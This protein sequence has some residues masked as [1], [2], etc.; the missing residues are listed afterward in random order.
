M[1]AQP[2]GRGAGGATAARRRDRA[3]S[4]LRRRGHFGGAEGG[5][6][7]GTR[8]E[9]TGDRSSGLGQGAAR[10][11]PRGAA[12]APLARAHLPR[13]RPDRHAVRRDPPG[14]YTGVEDRRA[15][16][17][18]RHGSV[19]SRRHRSGAVRTPGRT[20]GR[21]R[22]RL[23]ELARRDSSRRRRSRI[24]AGAGAAT[25]ARCF[26]GDGP[27][28]A[29]DARAAARGSTA[30]SSPAPVPHDRHAGARSRRPTSAWRPS[31][32]SA[33]APLALGFY[34]SPLKIFEYMASG[35][36]VVA[37]RCDGFLHSSA[38]GR[39]GLLYAGGV[40]ALADALERL[41]RPGAAARAWRR[42]PRA[43][44]PRVQLGRAL[45]A[46]EAAIR[47]ARPVP[48]ESIQRPSAD[49]RVS[50]AVRRQRL[51][52]VRARPR[53]PRPRPRRDDRPAAA[54]G[55]PRHHRVALRRIHGRWFGAPAPQIPYVRNYY[56]SETAHPLARQL[57]L[58]PARVGAPSTRPRPAR[59]DDARRPSPRRRARQLPSSPRSA[60]TGPSATGPT[61]STRRA[62]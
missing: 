1:D 34:W 8:G 40:E 22:R 29:A 47:S 53:A 54:R 42:R 46:L 5:R 12:D 57:P 51:E 27:E 50:A 28:L 49:R 45:R 26:I 9:R 6:D 44:G 48:H 56:K 33:H 62:A 55:A 60:T 21:L 13:I 31:T 20:A 38:D 18:R 43:R 3:L 52:H 23:P 16:V 11:A 39:E 4:Q 15:R 59:D 35:L 10:P 7:R 37:P 25:S 41:A 30:S 36:P 14:G 19:P 24:S 58:R 61:S 32:S 17:G 2:R